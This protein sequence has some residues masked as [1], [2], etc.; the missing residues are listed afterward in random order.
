MF[1]QSF[2]FHISLIKY[3]QKAL[4]KIENGQRYPLNEHIINSKWKETHEFV[5]VLLSFFWQLGALFVMDFMEATGVYADF[6]GS[7]Q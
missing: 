3:F 7:N 4:F 6:S 2:T 1:K 5:C